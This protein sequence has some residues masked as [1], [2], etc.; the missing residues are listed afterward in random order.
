MAVIE[1][2]DVSKLYGFGDATTLALDEVNLTIEKGEF[3]AVMGASGCGK[4][5]LMNVL[6]LLD[7]PTHGV[8]K[9]DGRL[10][11]RL[12]AAQSAKIRRD[13]IGFVFQS[14]NLLPR[15]TVLENVALPLT[16]KGMTL[17]KRMK[18][19]SNVLERVGMQNREYFLPGQLS[20]GQVQC[21]AIARALVND[22]QLLI[23]DEPTGNLDSA[24]SRLIMELMSEVHKMGH[25]I[26]F[27]T[28]N[29]EL[30]RYAT[31]VV[32]MHDG[33]IVQDE[34]TALGRVAPTALRSMYSV[35]AAT[36]E[37]DLAGVSALMKAVPDKPAKSAARA[38]SKTAKSK[39]KNTSRAKK[40]R[41]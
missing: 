7:K 16:Y 1:L 13:R 37:D 40:G 10:V 31:R 24:G 32:Y 30:T 15:M 25:T 39:R 29:P 19:A 21:A 9:L 33:T 22:P 26:I 3:V 17:A 6:G 23:A 18:T 11:S 38:K 2:Q 27:V 14:F 34:K 41:A 20:G 28:H 5:T 4:S 8:Y 35:A 12:S 36:E